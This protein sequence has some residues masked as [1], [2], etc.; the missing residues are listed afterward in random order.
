MPVSCFNSQTASIFSYGHSIS[1]TLQHLGNGY[2]GTFSPS[3]ENIRFLLVVV[4]YMTKW[5]EAKTVAH[6][7]STEG[8]VSA[9][10]WSG[11][12]ASSSDSEIETATMEEDEAHHENI[13]IPGAEEEQLFAIESYTSYGIPR[14]LSYSYINCRIP[15]ELAYSKI[16]TPEGETQAKTESEIDTE[17]EIMTETQTRRGKILDGI[18]NDELFCYNPNIEYEPIKR[19][20]LPKFAFYDCSS[21][22]WY[23][24]SNCSESESETKTK[25]MV[26]VSDLW[27]PYGRDHR[28]LNR[29]VTLQPLPSP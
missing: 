11:S 26:M 24:Y 14:E 4:D 18:G 27:F 2:Y 19:Y 23:G 22:D 8:D 6:T 5:V 13:V 17:I 10:D 29:N 25:S 12:Y 16:F 20:A 21:T 9:T 15:K 3:K 7:T 28:N 1:H